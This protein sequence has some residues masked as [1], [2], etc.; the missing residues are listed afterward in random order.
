MSA[1]RFDYSG[2]PSTGS[3]SGDVGNFFTA[4]SNAAPP[5]VWCSDPTTCTQRLTSSTVTQWLCNTQWGQFTQ[6]VALCIPA[7]QLQ[8][9][10]WAHAV[11]ALMDGQDG[12]QQRFYGIAYYETNTRALPPP[13]P[14][15]APDEV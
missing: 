11:V 13:P 4:L 5:S 2:A 1:R 10:Y 14:S 8:T 7:F 3:Y 15:E 6:E 9:G 12:P